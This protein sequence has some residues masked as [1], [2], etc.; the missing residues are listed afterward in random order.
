MLNTEMLARLRVFLDEASADLYIDTTELYPALSLAQVELCKD[1]ANHWDKNGRKQMLP[2]PLVIRDLL[3]N[4]TAQISL[5]AN[6]FAKTDI[7]LLVSLRWNPAGA[8]TAG[9]QQCIYTSGSGEFLKVLENR[10]LSD[11]YYYYALGGVVHLNPVST[12]NA[13]TY[14]LEYI[15]TPADISSSVQ[16]VVQDIGHDAIVERA[17]WI[18]LKDR[19]TEQANIHLQMYGKLLQGLV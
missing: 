16:P 10:Y 7:I 19:E 2:I 1:V 9:G 18:L 12:D 3:T 13:A 5:G 4:S 17:C 8:L 11:G 6:T 14:D 15:D